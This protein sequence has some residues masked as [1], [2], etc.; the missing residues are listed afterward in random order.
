MAHENVRR[1][2]AE[3]T[4][5]AKNEPVMSFH[6]YANAALFAGLLPSLPACATNLV[7][8]NGFGFAV[9]SPQAAGITKFYAHPYSWSLR[10]AVFPG[11]EFK[12]VE[13]GRRRRKINNSAKESF[14]NRLF[15]Y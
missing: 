4:Q 7:T 1:E 5:G 11:G 8:G 13:E 12:P 6:R 10:C 14:Q 9:V 2:V 15:F 3:F